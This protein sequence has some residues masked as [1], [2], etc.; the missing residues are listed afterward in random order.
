MVRSWLSRSHSGI[1][2]IAGL[3]ALYGLYEVIR[4]AGTEN[5]QVAMR[6]TDDIV[7]VEQT[8]GVYVERG[9]QQA[10]EGH[11][12]RA[13]AARSALRDAAFRGHGDRA[14]V[15]P[16]QAPRP[17]PARADDLRGRDRAR[18]GR[19]RPLPRRA[20]AA[21][22]AGLLRHGDALDEAQ[23]EL[24]PARRALQ[25]VRRRPEPPLRLRADHRRRARDHRAAS[26]RPDPRRACTR[27]RCS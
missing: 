12:V 5:V 1:R 10:F 14:H 18:A 13:G 16:P 20:S 25:P 11:P 27:R 3:A 21:R 19:L 26:D 15:D 4:G 23:P 8:L 6:H 24:R 2:E 22:R 9:V 7:A 17:V